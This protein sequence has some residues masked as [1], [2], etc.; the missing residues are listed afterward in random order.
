MPRG[1]QDEPE[2]DFDE[3][4]EE[5][6]AQ[7]GDEGYGDDLD[8]EDGEED[9]EDY[10]EDEEEDEGG[11]GFLK[12]LLF[13]FAGLIVVGGGAY[14]YMQG[15]L[16]FA[17]KAAEIPIEQA[18]VPSAAPVLPASP[19]VATP[20]AEAVPTEAPIVPSIAPSV[21]EVAEV[22]P[23]EQPIEK[24]VVV[25][26]T[27]AAKVPTK[28][29]SGAARGKKKWTAATTVREAKVKRARGGRAK[30]V[31]I[32]GSGKGPFTV[33]CGAFSEDGNARSLA[34]RLA[35]AG[36]KAGVSDGSDLRS[37]ATTVRS[38]VVNSAARARKLQQEMA[39]LGH[40]GSIIR[41]GK[42][43]YVLQLGVF[44]SRERASELA[45]EL[46]GKGAYV[47]LSGGVARLK[48]PHKVLVGRFKSEGPA[49]DVARQIRRQGIPA[50][51][52][53]L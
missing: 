34:S 8:D 10:D 39:A 29:A 3:N 11:G 15:L 7:D 45:T 31:A 35:A 14:A 49:A 52:V 13:I 47:S 20:V 25:S 44:Q 19:P 12:P 41:V 37:S 23:V 50:I 16:P 42:G 26:E 21:A 53:H 36:F 9:D 32:R 4:D 18:L 43:R 27:R 38:T 51:V 6:D 30:P 46:R 1:R 2:F 24:P 33:Q 17:P 28:V 22:A 40:P 5:L 48:A